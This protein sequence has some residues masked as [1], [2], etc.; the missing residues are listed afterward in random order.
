M[1]YINKKNLIFWAISTVLFFT[2]ISI[3]SNKI[4]Y[5]SAKK[6]LLNQRLL[7]LESR[8]DLVLVNRIKNQKVKVD[9]L[10]QLIKMNT[11]SLQQTK[12]IK[13][14]T[15]TQLKRLLD[16]LEYWMDYCTWSNLKQF[17]D[18]K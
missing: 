12:T 8:D 6:E 18:L 11:T 16:W 5:E 1:K 14:C 2:L 7:E 15:E 4:T 17:E 3:I 13:A 10:E 9:N